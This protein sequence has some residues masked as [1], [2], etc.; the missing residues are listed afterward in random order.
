[1]KKRVFVGYT[2]KAFGPVWTHFNTLNLAAIVCR[3]FKEAEDR[4]GID[5]VIR[6]KITFEETL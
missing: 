6:V 1:M 5:N 3:K 4:Y 2:V